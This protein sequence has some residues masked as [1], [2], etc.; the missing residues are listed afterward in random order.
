MT[1]PKP[2]LGVVVDTVSIAYLNRNMPPAI[3]SV[4]VAEP[5][6][7]Y[8]TGSYPPSPQVVEATNP[9]EYGIFLSIDSPRD[10]NDPG[11]KVFRK[12]YRTIT[13]RAHDDN[14]DSLRYTLAF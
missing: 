5:A 14:D 8:I 13:W 9:D 10:K 2:A 11:K 6:V 12:G 1:M 4:S 3:D 7:V